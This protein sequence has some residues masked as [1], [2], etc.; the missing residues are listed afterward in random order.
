MTGV[1]CGDA[2]M[3]RCGHRP[4][5]ALSKAVWRCDDVGYGDAMMGD[6]MLARVGG[7]A[8]REATLM[9]AWRC[10]EVASTRQCGHL[11]QHVSIPQVAKLQSMPALTAG[12]SEL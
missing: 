9:L 6:G 12:M 10:H 2:A 5:T 11:L 1:R 7:G 8:R 3:R 4:I